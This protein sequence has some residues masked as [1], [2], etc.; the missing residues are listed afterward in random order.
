MRFSTI[1][2]VSAMVVLSTVSAQTSSNL[3]ECNKCLTSAGIAAV[4]ACKGLE[5]TKVDDPSKGNAQQKKCWC[6]LSANK[7]WSDSCISSNKCAS[8]T[9]AAVQLVYTMIAAQPGICDGVSST[10]A[11]SNLCGSMMVGAAGAALAV[12]GA[13]L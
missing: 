11:G 6:G 5:N 3:E 2:A 13:L 10:N 8:D 4:P 12:A 1:L 7:S 9:V